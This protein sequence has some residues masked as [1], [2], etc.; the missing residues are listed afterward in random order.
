MGAQ[1]TQ[2]LDEWVREALDA[3]RGVVTRYVHE[4]RI[5]A[6]EGAE[7]GT[8]GSAK[9]PAMRTYVVPRGKCHM[10]PNMRRKR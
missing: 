4:V 8:G 3:L 6:H 10:G 2:L 7:L 5:A 9:H 1:L